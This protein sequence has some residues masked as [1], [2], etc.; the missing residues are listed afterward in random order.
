M[1]TIT[2]TLPDDLAETFGA[3][4]ED[5]R[6]NYAVAWMRAGIAAT[7]EDEEVDPEVIVALQ[8]SI[9]EVEAG[10]RLLTLE[11]MEASFEEFRAQRLAEKAKMAEKTANAGQ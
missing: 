6:N 3:L 11:E 10:G 7:E 5:E 2:L 4:P 9:A 1:T 8:E